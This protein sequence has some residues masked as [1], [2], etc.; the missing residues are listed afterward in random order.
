MPRSRRVAS[1]T[2]E[3]DDLEETDEED[4]DEEDEDEEEELE[5]SSSLRS[6]AGAWKRDLL[7]AS[8]LGSTDLLRRTA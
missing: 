4:E 2:S 3:L 6:F 1:L 5:E 7:K 8:S